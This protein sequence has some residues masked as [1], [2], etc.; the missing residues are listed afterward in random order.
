MKLHE[1]DYMPHHLKL[2]LYLRA[3]IY[4]NKGK[5]DLAIQDYSKIIE[6]YSKDAEV[7]YNLGRVKKL[8]KCIDDAKGDLQKGLELANQTRNV[9]VYVQVKNK[10]ELIEKITQELDGLE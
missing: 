5:Y 9:Q 4:E 2:S 7:Y 6:V 10:E 3:E 8:L 1:S